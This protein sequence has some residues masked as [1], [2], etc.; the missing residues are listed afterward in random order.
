MVPDSEAHGCAFNSKQGA[1]DWCQ[2]FAAKIG[3][4]CKLFFSLA[5]TDLCCFCNQGQCI[6][7][8]AIFTQPCLLQLISLSTDDDDDETRMQ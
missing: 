5:A 2:M 8:E 1:D 3:Y 4:L 7:K 6:K